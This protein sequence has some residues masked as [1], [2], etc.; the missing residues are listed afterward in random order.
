MFRNFRNSTRRPAPCEV[1][2]APSAMVIITDN[3]GHP[4]CATCLANPRI[5]D[6]VG[7]LDKHD[8]T[9]YLA[10]TTEFTPDQRP[11]TSI[12]A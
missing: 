7:E 8:W 11:Y 12:G 5:T 1:C 9:D 4:L 2:E 3:G 10:Q 6:A